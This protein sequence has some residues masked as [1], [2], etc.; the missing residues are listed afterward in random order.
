MLALLLAT[1]GGTWQV[2]DWRYGKQLAEQSGLHKDDL[3]LISKAAAAQVRADQDKRLVLEQRL[4][5]S[6]KTATRN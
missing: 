1:A 2:Q 4:T 6:K 3:A 5:A